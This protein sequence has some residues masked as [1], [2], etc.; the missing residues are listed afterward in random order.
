MVTLELTVGLVLAR[1]AP[2]STW[3]RPIWMPVQALDQV[4]ETPAW[5]RLS[6]SAERETFYAGAFP[7]MVY[8]SETGFYRDNLATGTPKLWVVMQPGEGPDGPDQRIEIVQ[9]TADPTE[10]EGHTQT[11]TYVVE[12]VDMPALTAAAVAEFVEQH[13]V[14]RVFEKRKRDRKVPLTPGPGAPHDGAKR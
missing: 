1:Y 10:G 3:G 12:V 11:G 9:V 2:A 13:H 8:A 14:E 5:S 7:V 4:P 6:A